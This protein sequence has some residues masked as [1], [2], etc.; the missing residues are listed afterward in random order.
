MG[1]SL[2]MDPKKKVSLIIKVFKDCKYYE[3][4]NNICSKTITKTL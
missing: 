4:K 2:S 3:C 1:F